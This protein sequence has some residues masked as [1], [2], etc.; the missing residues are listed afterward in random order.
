MPICDDLGNLL[1]RVEIARREQIA[2]VAQRLRLA[3]HHQFVRQPA[4]LGAL[5]AV[6]AAS[7]PGFRGKALAGIGDAERAVD[8]DF[9]FAI[10]RGADGADFVERKFARQ[11]DAAG[12]RGSARGGRPRHR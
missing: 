3:I 6:G 11:G 5:A 7:A 9:E 2:R 4:G 8:E 1:Q 10:G 12:A